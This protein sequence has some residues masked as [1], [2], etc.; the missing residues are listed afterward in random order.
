[1]RG[2]QAALEFAGDHSRKQRAAV[3]DFDDLL[4]TCRDVLR[5]YPPVRAA[6][7]ERFSRILVDEFQDTDPVRAE[8]AFLLSSTADE[9]ETWSKRR[10]K[11]PANPSKRLARAQAGGPRKSLRPKRR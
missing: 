11:A 5:A 4:F 10:L 9:A 2:P 3:L 6:A 8:I 1:M 7:S